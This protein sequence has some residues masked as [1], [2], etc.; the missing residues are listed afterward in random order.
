VGTHDGESQEC[1]GA[2]LVGVWSVGNRVTVGPY[3]VCWVKSSV[4][5]GKEKGLECI[6]DVI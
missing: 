3:G 1:S 6:L 5:V 2:T 4:R